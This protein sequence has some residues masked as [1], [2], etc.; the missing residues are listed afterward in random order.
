MYLTYSPATGELP[1]ATIEN[2]T[3]IEEE[4]LKRDD[5]DIVQVSITE[6]NPQASMMVGGGGALMYL[7]FNP[8][9]KNFPEVRDEI[10]EYVFNVGQS[11]GVEESKLHIYGIFIK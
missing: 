3:E 2:V 6:N 8:D 5:I 7:I 1:E 9:M 11:G 10:E 4:M